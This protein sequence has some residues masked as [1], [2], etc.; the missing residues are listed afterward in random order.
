VRNLNKN[1]GK[2]KELYNNN[3]NIKKIQNLS[4]ESKKSRLNLSF[5]RHYYHVHI[6]D[7][8]NNFFIVLVDFTK[9]KEFQ[10][11]YENKVIDIFSENTSIKKT[12]EY[13]KTLNDIKNIIKI[14]QTNNSITTMPNPIKV[15]KNLIFSTG[16]LGFKK[17]NRSKKYSS[18]SVVKHIKKFFKKRPNIININFII[19]HTRGIGKHLKD[20]LNRFNEIKSVQ[21]I[22]L[23][24]NTRIPFNGCR[25]K[26]IRRL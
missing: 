23:K 1:I 14:D 3:K 12:I 20:V 22:S 25:A 17:T 8:K 5:L 9:N 19:I 11:E 21:I 26:K 16:Q 10:Q 24:D 7:N 4:I 2:I 6:L 15:N 13:T 18:I